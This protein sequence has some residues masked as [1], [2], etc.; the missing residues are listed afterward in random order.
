MT[1]SP[2]EGNLGHRHAL[3]EVMQQAARVSS[4]SLPVLLTGESGTG[5]ELVAAAIHLRS[6]R[7]DRPFIV[8][9]CATISEVVEVSPWE[10]ADGGTVF[11]D[12][13]AELSSALQ[14]KLMRDLQ[15]GEIRVIAATNRDLEREV[16]AGKFRTDLFYRLN[17]VSITLPPLRER[18]Q[19]NGAVDQ[20][21]S[22]GL[23]PLSE[24]EGR[25]VAKVLAHTR[26]NK[27]AAARV[28]G[29]DRKTLDRMIKRHHIETS[30][31][32]S[33]AKP[34]TATANSMP[35]N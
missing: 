29:V 34:S 8:V 14:T 31:S 12:E 20:S 10:R 13:I 21:E 7:A 16:A 1:D 6:P 25:Y 30:S 28:L 9:N 33:R 24:I 5:K 3:I 11:F 22:E 19:T 17:P 15:S 35:H 18:K 23:V 2:T 32:R 27:Q 4:T 26:G